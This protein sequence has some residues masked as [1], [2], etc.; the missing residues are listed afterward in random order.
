[1]TLILCKY[2]ANNLVQKTPLTNIPLF[3]TYET[4]SS[5]VTMNNLP[6]VLGAFVVVI[7]LIGVGAFINIC[8]KKDSRTVPV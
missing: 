1:M 8:Y 6:I 7:V 4:T 5:A 2:L 3:R